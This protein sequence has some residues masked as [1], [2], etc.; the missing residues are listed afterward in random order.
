MGDAK[1]RRML[2]KPFPPVEIKPD[3]PGHRYRCY[4][5]KEPVE[6]AECGCDVYAR[7]DARQGARTIMA[8]IAAVGSVP[9]VHR[10]PVIL[11]DADGES[12]PG[13]GR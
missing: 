3:Q 10:D 12:E 6:G 7:L 4:K 2:L 8:A 13:A 9:I 5:S 1:R 11:V